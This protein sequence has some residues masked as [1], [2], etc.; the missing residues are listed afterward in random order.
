MKLKYIDWDNWQENTSCMQKPNK[1]VG[2]DLYS[3]KFGAMCGPH[4]EC[5][6]SIQR[7][8]GPPG[9]FNLSQNAEI[10]YV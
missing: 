3:G 4:N 8:T 1:N 2:F 5:V 10:Y 7:E 6:C 9:N